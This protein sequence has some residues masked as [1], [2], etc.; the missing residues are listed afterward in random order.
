MM[1]LPLCGLRNAYKNISAPAFSVFL[2]GS[3]LAN[4]HGGFEHAQIGTCPIFDR[5]QGGPNHLNQHLILAAFGLLSIYG[6]AA[7][8]QSHGMRKSVHATSA[9]S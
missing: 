8:K 4:A 6:E 7:S 2:L 5:P 1:A 9:T 3:L